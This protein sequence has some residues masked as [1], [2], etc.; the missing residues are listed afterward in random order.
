MGPGHWE[1]LGKGRVEIGFQVLVLRWSTSNRDLV[2]DLAVAVGVS[3]RDKYMLHTDL[4]WLGMTISRYMPLP[5][6][7]IP[8]PRFG[9]RVVCHWLLAFDMYP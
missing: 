3:S 4:G 9:H 6:Q 2:L 7:P 5:L 8:T 1:M